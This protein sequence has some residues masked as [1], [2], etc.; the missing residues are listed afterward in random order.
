M[1]IDPVLTTILILTAA[2][3]IAS[4]IVHAREPR[5]IDVHHYHYIVRQP[6]PPAISEYEPGYPLAARKPQE[7]ERR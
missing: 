1:T 5:R 4:A 6:Q 2:V 3:I 7:I